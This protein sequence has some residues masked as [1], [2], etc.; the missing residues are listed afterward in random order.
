MAI[1]PELPPHLAQARA[2]PVAG[3]TL[4]PVA[5]PSLPSA[6]AP[7]H[8]DD[9]DDDDDFGPALPPDL[10][11]E[12][13]SGSNESTVNP[14]A[15]PSRPAV[16]GPEL[17]PHLASRSRSP[18]HGPP[19]LGPTLGPT[20][21][22]RG[23]VYSGPSRSELGAGGPEDDDD[24][25]AVGPLPLPEGYR[26][27][28]DNGVQQF[29]EREE[30]ERKRKQEALE[31]KKPKREEWM[32][33]PP[34]EMDLLS[35]MDTTK[36]KSRGFATGK[37][38]QKAA[39][40]STSEGVNLW[41]ETPAERQ[42]RLRDEM[43]GKKRKA[44]NAPAEEETDDERRKRMRDQQLRE[45]VERHNRTKRGESLLDK[46]AK[47]AKKAGK[48]GDDRAATAIW[49]RDRDMGVGGRLMDD[50]QRASA[51]KNAKGL[52]GRFGGGSFL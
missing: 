24:D 20:M 43:L 29:R 7:D 27:E 8:D 36:L 1:G 5:G 41:T 52:G 31:D 4:P 15:G 12:R 40:G 47:D 2:T 14:V 19:K 26:F 32:L 37:A 51:V 18:A 44:E 25:D 17:P 13:Q 23:D 50:G 10:Q 28:D 30:R 48:D 49:D 9:D 16:S 45:E 22:S 21:P 35:S 39:G 42:E 6:A 3:P 38:A 11:A 33:V 46:H 34:K